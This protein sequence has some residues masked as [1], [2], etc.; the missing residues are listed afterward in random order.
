MNAGLAARLPEPASILIVKPSSLGDIVHTLPAVAALK[1]AFP[2]VP[3]R[4]VANTEWMPLLEGSPVVDNVLEFPRRKFRGMGV[5]T[6]VPGWLRTWRADGQAASPE[7]VLDFQ[8]LLRS[9][10]M[11]K[12]RGS[13]PVIGLSDS[14]EG[15][16]RFHTHVVA[17][18]AG[19][20]AVERYLE[21]P[22]AL[23]VG[24]LPPSEVRFPLPA[25]RLPAGWPG[26]PPPIVVHPWSRGQGKSLTQEQLQGLCEKLAPHPVVVVG[27]SPT[28]SAPKLPHVSD[29]A[30]QTSLSEL[31]A[32]MREAAWCISVDSGPMHI[33]AAVNP[34]TL[35][36]HTWTD[37][38]KVGPYNP[39]CW[40]W[41]AGRIDHRT[42]FSGS[43]CVVDRPVDA[44]AIEAMAAFVRERLREKH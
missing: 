39:Q 4:W 15:A 42:G 44:A 35:G 43:E 26:G 37:P 17:V 29:L 32:L 33:A 38:R 30:N 14:R 40:I 1:A 23:G 19:A 6:Q 13:G 12:S 10:L 34:R 21:M 3:I 41:K 9:A 8:G 22:H 27:R 25:G 20:H 36:I 18:D 5:L 7:W 2:I 24:V 16:R 31:I 28:E 11:A